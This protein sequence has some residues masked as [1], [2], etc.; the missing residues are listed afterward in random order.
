MKDENGEY[1][2]VAGD[3][4]FLY[5]MLEMAGDEHYKFIETINYVYN[6][7]NPINDHK[8]YQPMVRTLFDKIRKK[9]KYNKL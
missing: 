2:Q 7:E 8:I 5:P 9:E 6:E 4:A 1:W 3:L